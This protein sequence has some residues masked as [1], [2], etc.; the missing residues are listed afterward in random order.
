M[1][2]DTDDDLQSLK[3]WLASSHLAIISVDAHKYVN[4]T[5]QDVWTL[6]NYV[7]PAENHA[8]T[9]VGYDDNL[10]YAEQGEIRHGAF[11]IANSWGKGG[12]ER[13]ADGC[14][15][16]SYEAMKQ[17]VGQFMFYFDIVDY[18]PQLACSFRIEHAK[19]GECSITVGIG[20]NNSS[21]ITKRF[22]QYVSGGSFPFCANDVTLDVTEFKKA[23]PVLNN[24]SFFL[25]IRDTA[26]S[27]TGTLF[28]FAVNDAESDD[29]PIETINNANIYAYVT[30]TST[31]PTIRILSPENKTYAVDDCPLS[32]ILNE[33]VSLIQYSLD[34][35]ENRTITGN[36]T[37]TDLTQG[38]HSVSVYASDS[39]GNVGKS[40]AIHFGIDTTPPYITNVTEPLESMPLGTLLGV[41]ATVADSN[42]G[43]RQVLLN[44]TF[45]NDTSSW[46]CTAEMTYLT[47]CVWNG[48]IPTPI[49]VTNTTYEVIAEDNAGNRATS[50]CFTCVYQAPVAHEYSSII[51]LPLLL[52]ATLLL[53][54]IRKKGKKD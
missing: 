27:T 22:D 38:I 52:G 32:F 44:C 5:S 39:Y 54:T 1:F 3:N 19:R 17:R 37:L 24:Q 21:I 53:T 51:I 23:L 36:T 12:W 20:D 29:P 43:I 42:S 50:Q 18:K 2:L 49:S 35:Q 4:L 34:D 16:I 40:E 25:R 6:D 48:T 8:S 14:F 11:K 7:S 13:T 15:W 30:L 10:T 9:V 47:G 46:N 31:C 26:S 41:N 33:N 45:A 28:M